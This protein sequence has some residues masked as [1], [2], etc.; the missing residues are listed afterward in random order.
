M[1]TSDPCCALACSYICFHITVFFLWLCVCVCVCVCVILHHHWYSVYIQNS[2]KYN[3]TATGIG[4]G[5]PY[6]SM[7][8]LS[9]DYTC[10][11]PIS[12]QIYIHRHHG[13]WLQHIF[14]GDTMQST[15]W[16]RR[17]EENTFENNVI[18]L[19]KQVWWWGTFNSSMYF[20][21]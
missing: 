8:S 4:L 9:F 12:K 15:T 11:D 1:V 21:R 6:S 2:L 7:T 18:Y 20:T 16:G 17:C 14:L 13:L 10:K 3:I 5:P 19:V